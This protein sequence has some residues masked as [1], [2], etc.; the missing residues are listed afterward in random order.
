MYSLY[1]AVSLPGTS[2]SYMRYFQMLTWYLEM[3]R[4]SHLHLKIIYSGYEKSLNLD[5]IYLTF[6]SVLSTHDMYFY[7]PFKFW[8]EALQSWRGLLFGCIP[9]RERSHNTIRRLDTQLSASLKKFVLWGHLRVY[10]SVMSFLIH[11]GSL[12]HYCICFVTLQPD[13]MYQPYTAPFNLLSH[14]KVLVA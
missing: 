7:L 8:N 10:I 12:F 3:D 2:H 4:N 11:L 6:L 14:K 1:F 13:I 5:N 9:K